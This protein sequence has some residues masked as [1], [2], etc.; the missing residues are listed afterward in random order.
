MRISATQLW[1]T[2]LLSFSLAH[3]TLAA[4]PPTFVTKSASAETLNLLRAGG[5]VIYMRHG[6]TD[7]SRPDRVPQVDLNDC[8]TQRP[9]TEKGRKIASRVGEAMRR[10]GIPIGEVEASP[11]CRTRFTAEAAFGR[12]TVN[13][14]LMYTSNLTAKQKEPRIANTRRL[15]STPVEAGSNRVIVAH[16]PN[17]MDVIGYFPTPEAIVV[18]FRPL[19]EQGFEYLA[20]IPPKEWDTLLK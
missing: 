5:L 12:Y 18:V 2:A 6:P 15:L 4:E 17:L 16:A 20:S 14:Y 19:G 7:T 1:L 10:A 8:A 11:M 9:L 3:G 13:P